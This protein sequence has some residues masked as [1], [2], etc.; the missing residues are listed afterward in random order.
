VEQALTE[1]ASILSRHRIV[2]MP[3]LEKIQAARGWGTGKE[4]LEKLVQETGTFQYEEALL[5]LELI[6]KELKLKQ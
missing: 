3:L 5:T 1:L 4:S 6:R 2:P